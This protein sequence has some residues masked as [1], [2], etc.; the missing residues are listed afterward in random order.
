[1]CTQRA[2]CTFITNYFWL[3]KIILTIQLF[4]PWHAKM[5]MHIDSFFLL[6]NL[7]FVQRETKTKELDIRHFE[8]WMYSLLFKFLL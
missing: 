6:P 3:A 7:H 8:H 4:L 1:M 2:Y 5:N